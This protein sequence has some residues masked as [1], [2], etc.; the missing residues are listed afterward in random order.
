[1]ELCKDL[2]TRGHSFVNA[3]LRE[4]YLNRYSKSLLTARAR[5]KQSALEPAG[6]AD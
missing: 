2:A 6:P 1:M 5:S 4:D 3:N